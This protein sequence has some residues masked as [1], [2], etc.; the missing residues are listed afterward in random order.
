MTN[1][2]CGAIELLT[3]YCVKEVK[4]HTSSFRIITL[5]IFKNFCVDIFL[6]H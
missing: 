6:R 1:S 5:I 3:W 2:T 4:Q